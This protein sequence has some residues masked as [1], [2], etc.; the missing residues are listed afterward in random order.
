MSD[1]NVFERRWD[2]Q[3]YFVIK[4]FADK[5]TTRRLRDSLKDHLLK[6]DLKRNH[7]I[8][9]GSKDK[10]NA[11]RYFHDSWEKV[12][13]FYEE[14]FSIKDKSP[15]ELYYGLN[16]VGHGLHLHLEHFKKFAMDSRLPEIAA[17]AGITDMEIMQ[18]MV[19]F[20]WPGIGGE[21][22]AHQDQ[23]YLY[24]D[25]HPV[26]GFWIALEDANTDNSCLWVETGGHKK[27]LSRRYFR[28]GDKTWFENYESEHCWSKM[29]PVRVVEGDLIFF[30]GLLPHGSKKNTSKK[31]RQA[32][33]FHVKDRSWEFSPANWPIGKM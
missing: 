15:E 32:L 9:L 8:F 18:S 17:Y 16:K 33:T 13:Y 4:N 20:K 26:C 23:T 30:N 22:D 6:E 19:I 5:M 2:E 14:D 27:G 3:G 25:P 7:S 24:T 31:S 28:N 12:S 1:L 29:E 11:D 21:V 10:Q